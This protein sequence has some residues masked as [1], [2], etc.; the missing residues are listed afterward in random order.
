MQKTSTTFFT[1][2]LTPSELLENTVKLS[3]CLPPLRTTHT[4]PLILPH[5]LSHLLTEPDSL[6]SISHK[7]TS[8]PTSTTILRYYAFLSNSIAQLKEELERHQM[9]QEVVYNH[10]FNNRSF[11]NRIRPII[12]E[13]QQ[14]W[15]LICQGFHPYSHTSDSPNIPSANNS[16]STNNS[17][18]INIPSSVD[19]GIQGRVSLEIHDRYDNKSLDPYYTLL[20]EGLG[21]KKHPIIG[22]RGGEMWR[23]SRRSQVSWLRTHSPTTFPEGTGIQKIPTNPI[24]RIQV[25]GRWPDQSISLV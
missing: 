2:H 10:L 16:P 20:D 23:M 8:K 12:N 18:S 1:P 22:C 17:P 21:L 7:F 14:K 4:L 24:T 25:N 15:V 5:H 9:E 11:Q 19:K 3:T 6:H 13:Y